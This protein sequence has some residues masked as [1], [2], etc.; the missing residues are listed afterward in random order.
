MPLSG[1]S[2]RGACVTGQRIRI[3]YPAYA[4]VDPAHVLALGMMIANSVP[5]ID[6]MAMQASALV[7][8]NRNQL[9]EGVLGF[10]GPRPTHLLWI[11]SDTIPPPDM[12][13]RLL[14][15][16]KAI[17]SGLY[18]R[19]TGAHENL[20]YE[21]NPFRPIELETDELQ[22]VG[23]VG[24]GCCL[25]RLEVYEQMAE[26]FGDRFWH[27]A[28]YR[29]A[30]GEDVWFFARCKAMGLEVWVDPKVEVGHLGV[31][32]FRPQPINQGDQP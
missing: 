28:D 17:C 14:A 31:V 23:G 5:L 16:D 2:L 25:V 1:L 4:P 26:R 27:H 13:I 24:L 9:V 12:P 19:R 21:V 18:V 8:W 22:P 7:D 15:H 32:Q 30:T 29:T 3:A 6:G 20:V 10:E 11:D